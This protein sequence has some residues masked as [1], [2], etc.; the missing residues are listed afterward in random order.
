[1]RFFTRLIVC[2]A[3][4]MLLSAVLF[5]AADAW[6]GERASVVGVGRQIVWESRRA[7]ALQARAE[8]TARSF[9][10]KRGII[11]QLLAGRLRFR[12]AIQQFQAANELVR[13]IDLDLL[14][15]YQTPTC[16]QG[17]AR[18]VFMWAHNSVASWPADKAQRLLA[19]LEC[20]YQTMFD[21]SKPDEAD[22]SL[23]LDMVPTDR[24][25][26]NFTD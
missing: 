14:P 21:G 16:P 24:T 18:Q 5:Y 7:E 4:A 15:P 19:A 20:E 11:D 23:P 3:A 2:A 10:A 9:A 13:N 22:G 6:L 8:M 1:M 17:V 25:T 26:A 12:Q